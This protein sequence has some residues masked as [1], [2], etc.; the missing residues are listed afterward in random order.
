MALGQG[1]L[2][3]DTDYTSIYNKIAAVYGRSDTGYGQTMAANPAA[4]DVTISAAEWQNLRNYVLNSRVHQIGTSATLAAISAGQVITYST[5]PQAIN[6]MANLC[7]TDNRT[8]H[9][10]Q[11]STPAE[12][13]A[14]YSN[15]SGWG[16]TAARDTL[17]VTLRITGAD[18]NGDGTERGL[19]YFFNAGGSIKLRFALTAI[20]TSGAS[21]T[22]SLNWQQLMTNVGTITFNHNTTSGAGNSVTSPAG[23]YGLTL[24]GSAVEIYRRNASGEN[25]YTEN[26]FSITAQRFSGYID[27]KCTWVDADTGDQRPGYLP[28]PGVDEPVIGSMDMYYTQN[29][30]S[31]SY[32]SVNPVVYSIPLA[33]TWNVS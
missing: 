32:V 16:N 20:P 4:N 15:A 14:S 6:D 19:K 30:P 7:V 21:Y 11:F 33:T 12:G 2:V 18:M 25:V 10:S 28:G 23:F 8:I 24:N 9:S 1:Q 5:G 31:G 29:Q 17:S 3:E 13:Y 22:K 26:Y 27:F